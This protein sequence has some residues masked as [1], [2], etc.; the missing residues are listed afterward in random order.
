MRSR[1]RPRPWLREEMRADLR[2]W[3][4]LL[5]E[6]LALES[7]ARRPLCPSGPAGH[8]RRLFPENG[9]VRPVHQRRLPLDGKLLRV[10]LGAVDV[11][12]P[13]LARQLVQDLDAVPIRIGDVHAMG[14]AVVDAPMKRHALA[15]EKLQLLE[16]RLAV[17][18]G[19]GHVVDPRP[20][21]HQVP[22]LAVPAVRL[23]LLDFGQRQVVM[24]HVALRVEP[25][26]EAHLRPLAARYRL[27]LGHA[28][29]ADD[30]GPEPMR[31][32]QVPHVQDEVI[33]STRRLSL[34]S[35]RIFL[36]HVMSLRYPTASWP[37]SSLPEAAGAEAAII[38]P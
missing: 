25:A 3:P 26:V 5:L 30:L 32:F 2:A 36:R 15:L 19:D 16:P 27:E 38:L 31:H 12:L 34:R 37:P 33:D 20:A 35:W 14:H 29:E 7:L 9:V 17:R 10:V 28:A 6:W 23:G 21:G 24:G 18:P 13:H 11:V 22:L 8:G 4:S 1:R